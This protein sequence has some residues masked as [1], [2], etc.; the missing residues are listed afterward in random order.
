MMEP[1][2][3]RVFSF[4]NGDV[5]YKF[6]LVANKGS[7]KYVV[8]IQSMHNRG[9]IPVSECMKRQRNAWIGFRITRSHSLTMVG[10]EG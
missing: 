2:N 3:M 5:T 9:A 10:N 7:V 1:I 6:K 4:T 8:D